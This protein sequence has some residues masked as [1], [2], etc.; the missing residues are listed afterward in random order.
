MVDRTAIENVPASDGSV[1]LASASTRDVELPGITLRSR[2]GQGH[3]EE[4]RSFIGGLFIS[5]PARAY[6]ENMAPSRARKGVARRLSREELEKRL[7]ADIRTRGED[8]IKTLRDEARRIAPKLGLEKAQAQLDDIIGT[9]LGTRDA[10]IESDIAAARAAGRPFDPRRADLFTVLYEELMK[11]NAPIRRNPDVAG[12]DINLP[13][14][15]AYFSNF[16]E[17]T[18]FEVSEAAEIIFE[19]RI[20]EQRPADA[21]DIL[22][23]YR[24]VSSRNE[25]SRLPES[26]EQFV[27]LMR[28]RHAQV[29]E[30]RPDKAPGQFK[31]RTNQAGTTVFVAP[32]L[33][34]GTLKR[35]FDIYQAIGEP[36][37][38]A[39]YMMFLVAEVHPFVDGNGRLARIMMNAEL[40][41]ANERRI[42]IPTIYRNNYLAALRAL[43]QN[44]AAEPVIRMLNFIQKYTAAIDFSTYETAKSELRQ[45]NAFMDPGVADE[46]GVRLKL[47]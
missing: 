30:G 39:A 20:P 35:G 43:S 26:F 3:I 2:K 5:S 34:E 32:E 9:L 1:F 7:D 41:A 38:R 15:E 12:E 13:F 36:F 37:H 24:V 4:D 47:P 21:H 28:A 16:I 19:G 18:E 40:V 14:F 45:T 46:E 23:T 17:G 11:T 31:T 44:Q 6:L 29:M 33:V 10:K 22:G 42:I 25:M 27:S 8:Y